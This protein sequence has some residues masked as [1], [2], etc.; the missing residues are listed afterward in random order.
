[1]AAVKADERAVRNERQNALQIVL[2]KRGH[3]KSVLPDHC[4]RLQEKRLAADAA[5]KLLMRDTGME[6]V[7][8]K[9]L[10]EAGIVAVHALICGKPGPGPE[11]NAQILVRVLLPVPRRCG[12]KPGARILPRL[13][14]EQLPYAL[15]RKVI[16]DKVVL[17]ALSKKLMTD[18]GQIHIVEGALP[19]LTLAG[20]EG[21]VLQH[22]RAAQVAVRGGIGRDKP[23]GG[24]PKQAD[25][26]PDD[27]P[28][29]VDARIADV[30]H[31]VPRRVVQASPVA[32]AV[33][34]VHME[35]PRELRHDAEEAGAVHGLRVQQHQRLQIVS[36][37]VIL[38]AGVPAFIKVFF[39][40]HL[41]K[42]TTDAGEA[43]LPAQ[44]FRL[45]LILSAVLDEMRSALA[46]LEIDTLPDA[47]FTDVEHPQ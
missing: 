7:I 11:R 17:L 32:V 6:A 42:C 47:L 12:D 15:M 45:K 24:M 44:V 30:R 33:H 2:P 21:R 3:Q 19:A 20:E 18:R 40:S 27:I 1:M 14:G 25:R 39:V 34:G 22:Q 36:Y 16:E 46:E 9:R 10:A 13:F 4:F 35:V 31:I 28:D 23:A 38:K 26:L 8:I 41:P 43:R 29:E 5:Q 37:F